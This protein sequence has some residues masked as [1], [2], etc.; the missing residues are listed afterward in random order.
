MLADVRF[1]VRQ[2]VKA[3]GFTGIAVL[4]LALG[5]ATSTT[6]FT[7]FNALLVR[8]IPFLRDEATLL[9][10]R[11]V[12][13]KDPAHD[14]EFA[15]P[16]FNDV[17]AQATT[18]AGTLTT[19]N[20][21]YIIAGDDRPLRV[22]GSWITAD[23]F[24]TLGVQPALGR[25]FRPDEARPDKAHVA[26]LGYQLWQSRFGGRTDIVGETITLNEEPVTVVGVMP[27]GFRF[28]EVTDLW[29]PFP[30]IEKAE[31]KHRGE[32]GWPFYARMKAG[33]TLEQV[34]AELDT[35][36]ARLSAEHP[37]TN[38]G[39]TFR[40]L[41]VRDEATR[42]MRRHVQ[43]MLG[44]VLA[45]LLIACGNVANLLLARAAS[46]T[47]EIAVRSAVGAGRSRIIRQVMTESLLLGLVGGLAGLLLSSWQLDFVL[48][49]IPVEIPFWIRFDLDWRVF[50]FALGAMVFS[51]L[52]FGVLP[53][54]QI[55][56]PDF[57]NE[58]K[59]GGRGGT[60]S[61]RGKRARNALVVVQ[62]ALALVLL[63]VAGLTMRSFLALQRVDTGIQTE[64]ILTFRTGVP[65]TMMK[66]DQ[67]SLDFMANVEKRL[68]TIAGVEAAGFVSY[69]PM[70]EA[71]NVTTFLP[72]G[73]PEPKSNQE[74]PQA[75]VRVGTGAVFE[76][77]RIPLI[78][79]RIFDE[80]D[81]ADSTPVV[82][83]DQK[84]ARRF[85]PRGDAIGKRITFDDP[86][87]KRKW[88]TIVGIVGAVR[89]RPGDGRVDEPGVWQP[90]SQ[91]HENF[92]SAVLRVRGDPMSYVQAAQDAVNA[93]RPNIPIYYAESM[94]SVVRKALW[95]SRFFG[96]L[97]SGFAAIALFLA[98][99]GIYGVTAYSVSQRTQ[100][101]GVRMA[102]GAQP[103]AVI[104]MVLAEGARLVAFGLGLGFA[105]A[106]CVAQLLAGMLH[107]I[108]PHDPPTF[109]MVPLLLA[110]VA[111][112]ACYVPGRRATLIDPIVALRAE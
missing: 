29:Q 83:V 91:S 73:T 50:S 53:A 66:D 4:A 104:G 40:A 76:A 87:H 90:L 109:T 15:I 69:L 95:Q 108:D 27:R 26:I 60:G 7:F 70:T 97:F 35:I 56:R 78:S 63:V 1:A 85:Y 81:D 2:L 59:D 8:P 67:V 80:R 71:M 103:R 9:N 12:D 99:I 38:T 74:W 23:G 47:R 17:R 21:T 22:L 84:F 14:M 88:W 11:A 20:R 68:Q 52:L 57:T 3:P 19:W 25:V 112:F 18:L 61:G 102:L 93:V 55:S 92:A 13:S 65:P 16:D 96:G 10:I 98:A 43:M 45:V 86:G 28:P 32:H 33:V 79:G 30:Q 5:I 46:R 6:M 39:L 37:T 111:L 64:H 42:D 110:C 82:V 34:Q 62:M 101:I 48:S 36:A 49:F 105:V 100:E 72:E 75:T 41:K 44:A 54:W 24:Q 94:T 51:S 58:L 77:F 31:E 106:W 107:G 89:Q